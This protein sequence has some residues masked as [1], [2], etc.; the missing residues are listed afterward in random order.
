LPFN[1]FHREQN[2]KIYSLA[3]ATQMEKSHDDEKEG[4]KRSEQVLSINF[5]LG[6]IFFMAAKYEK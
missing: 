6:T 4:K 3:S 1:I 2:E 5:F